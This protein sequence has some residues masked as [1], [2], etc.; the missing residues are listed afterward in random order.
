MKTYETIFVLD[1]DLSEDESEKNLNKIVGVIEGQK[2]KIALVDHW[3]RRKLAYR[4]RK[5][6]KG[7]YVRLVYYGEGNL[8]AQLER[9]LRLLENVYK[10]LTV[11]LADTE[12]E[13]ED[14]KKER[15]RKADEDAK[16]DRPETEGQKVEL[17]DEPEA[18]PEGEGEDRR[19][20]EEEE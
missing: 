5:K 10:F 6:Y 15:E 11:K 4:V 1:P 14:K 9:N 7:N 19:I 17:S 2:G 13:V 18:K 3:G 20:A 16:R 8:V 12:V